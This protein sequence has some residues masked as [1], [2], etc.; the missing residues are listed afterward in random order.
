M[1]SSL[2]AIELT[3]YVFPAIIFYN[4]NTS[5]TTKH[6]QTFDFLG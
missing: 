1:H 3:C 4:W 6:A 2:C 5:K